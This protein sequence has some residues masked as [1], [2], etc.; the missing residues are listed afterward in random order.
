M[1]T[2]KPLGPT[3]TVQP[4]ETSVP[5]E[6]NAATRNANVPMGKKTAMET[7]RP[8]V[9]TRTARN[10]ETRAPMENRAYMGIV[11]ALKGQ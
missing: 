6:R 5:G 4:V 9:P 8:L 7:V 2:V 10:V 1:E 11:N 3:Q